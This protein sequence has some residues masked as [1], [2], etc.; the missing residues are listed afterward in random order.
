MGGHG[1]DTRRVTWTIGTGRVRFGLFADPGCGVLR[2]DAGVELLSRRPRLCGHWP[3]R[4]C[5]CVSER[6]WVS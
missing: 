3:S 2:W 4:E 5:E 6:S 1:E